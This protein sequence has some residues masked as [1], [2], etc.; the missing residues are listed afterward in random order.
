MPDAFPNSNY[1]NPSPP[2]SHTNTDFFL[3]PST[4]NHHESTAMSDP[5]PIHQP[6]HPSIRPLLDPEYVALHDSLIQYLL[7]TEHPSA[8]WT[9]ASRLKLSAM[10][11]CVQR[12]IPVGAVIDLTPSAES[13]QARVFVPAG[14]TPPNGWPALVWFHGGGW[15]N[16]GLGSEAGFLSHLCHCKYPFAERRMDGKLKS[17]W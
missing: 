12:P 14:E 11:H 10:A 17:G 9:P 8:Q 15:V 13:F 4:V 1:F 16:G 5:R 7:P 2:P 6:L 3:P